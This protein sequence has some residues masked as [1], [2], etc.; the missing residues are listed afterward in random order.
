MTV[1]ESRG[2]LPEDVYD[3]VLLSIRRNLER[4]RARITFPKTA[5]VYIHK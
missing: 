2:I 5:V 4:K 1:D 3:Q